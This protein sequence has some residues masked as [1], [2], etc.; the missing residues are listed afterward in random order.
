MA[1]TVA[2]KVSNATVA[3]HDEGLRIY[4]SNIFLLMMLGLAVT[5]VASM[6]VVNSPYLLSWMVEK[7]AEGKDELSWWWY[8]LV[9]AELSLVGNMS[10]RAKDPNL[11][12]LKGVLIFSLY[13]GLNGLTLSPV[14]HLFTTTSVLKVF[15]I[16]A[17]AFSSC[18]LWGYTTKRDL[19]GLGSFLV[20]G[21][22]GL[23]VV[24]VVNLFLHAP[25]IDFLV[26]AA[27]VLIFAGLTAWHMQDL[28]RLYDEEGN[29]IGMVVSGALSLYLAFLNLFQFLLIIFGIPVGGSGDDDD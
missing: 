12:V 10:D 6:A 25:A 22:F 9:F 2:K 15:L 16:T 7:G 11:G 20:I 27:G 26:C 29:T 13:A 8:G 4:M 18:A 1:R 19:T 23:L 28:R 14:I 5:G 21:L 24:M 17:S 3:V